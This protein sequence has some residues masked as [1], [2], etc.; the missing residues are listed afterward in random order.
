[1]KRLVAI[2]CVLA[3][4]TS[5]ASFADD[6]DPVF[7]PRQ[8]NCVGDPPRQTE[9]PLSPPCVAFFDGDNGGATYTG[10]TKDD[11]RIALYNDLGIKGEMNVPWDPSNES[12]TAAP[13]QINLVRTV[14]A[15]LR[16]FMQRFM[17]F[18][19][20][21]RLVAVPSTAGA[22]ES[23]AQR[24]ADSYLMR[25][26]HNPFAVIAF[27]D[28]MECFARSMSFDFK[29][30]V[31]LYGTD[32]SSTTLTLGAPYIW[33]FLPEQETE[34]AYSASF[35]CREL[36]GQTAR[37]ARSPL[38]KNSARTFGLITTDEGGPLGI[39][40]LGP[41]SPIGPLADL[42]VADAKAEC[43][44]T[45][46]SIDRSILATPANAAALMAQYEAK[47][48]TTVLCYCPVSRDGSNVTTMQSAA[49]AMG[50][51]PEWVWDHASRMD[52]P[53]NQ[54]RYASPFQTSLGVSYF[55]RLPSQQS[56]YPAQAYAQSE[57]GSVPN[58]R[59][60]WEIY[61]AFLLAFSAIQDAGPDLTPGTVQRGLSTWA[62]TDATN[63]FEPIGGYG[64]YGAHALGDQS[65][66][67]TG[68]AWWWDSAGTAPG[69][70]PTTGCMRVADEGARAYAGTWP[71]GDASLFSP[72]APC[73]GEPESA[74]ASV[75]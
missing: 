74:P 61:H 32:V 9:D 19:R 70:P 67:D 24:T 28:D 4:L 11:I 57:P 2:A 26:N 48:I 53:M 27:G 20:L 23:C 75:P 29:V 43:G 68:M 65:F 31:F 56:Q 41:D 71:E 14:K 12:A 33:S 66:V 45:F 69:A 30:P 13:D 10:V 35:L 54:R 50:Y 58:P 18:G 15:Q 51:A 64:P 8:K 46:D 38:L 5:V 63:T 16:F 22:T 34:A 21:V 36:R 6:G 49:T 3:T 39:G 17:T 72:S 1:M 25:K 60:N 47:G 37:F 55:W 59:Y 42:L 62:Y 7:V 52:N 40:L 44:L 73:S